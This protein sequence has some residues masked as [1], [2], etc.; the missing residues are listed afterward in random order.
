STISDTIA[1]I[2]E[3]EPAWDALPVSIGLRRLL[4]RCL[5]KEPNRRLHD[6][7]DARIEI[8]DLLNGASRTSPE[9][10]GDAHP[11]RGA[12]LSRVTAVLGWLVAIIAV[13]T[14]I[15][16]VRTGARA[17]TPS[18]RVSRTLLPTS[19]AATPSLNGA[20]SLAITPDG[21]H[22]VYVGNNGTQLF[23]SSLDRLDPTPLVTA[24]PPLNPRF[25]PPPRPLLPFLACLAP[26]QL[27]L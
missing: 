11:R 7:A 4:Q 26:P 16:Y 22:V 9:I 23:V 8:D 5:E 19:G 12:P 25:L 15:W 13:A 6:I 27:A 17:A 20:R 21:S 2:L 10:P 1:A 3:R 18:L 14:L 24:V